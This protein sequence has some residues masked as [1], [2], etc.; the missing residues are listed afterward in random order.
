MSAV[1]P[2]K[3]HISID[4]AVAVEIDG[5]RVAFVGINLLRG[6]V[7]VEYDIDPPITAQSPF[8]PHLLLIDATDD[9]SDERYGTAWEDFRWPHIAPGRTTTRLEHRPPPDAAWMHIAVRPLDAPTPD[10]HGP[11]TSSLRAVIEFDI[12]LPPEHGLA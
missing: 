3:L 11:G 1:R 10:V 2:R 4:P 8:E 6:H 12:E 5:H 7:M 9:T